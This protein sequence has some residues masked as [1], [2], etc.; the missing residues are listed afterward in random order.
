MQ[1]ITAERSG[2]MFLGLER[3]QSASCAVNVQ[4]YCVMF[5]LVALTNKSN[6]NIHIFFFWPKLKMKKMTYQYPIH[7][8]FF[9]STARRDLQKLK[10]VIFK[11][12]TNRIC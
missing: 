1:R 9:L 2:K 4:S 5:F 8:V 10:I 11:I 12:F 3:S 6:Q 7:I